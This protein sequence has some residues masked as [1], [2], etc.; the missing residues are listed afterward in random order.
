MIDSN[1]AL[2]GLIGYPLGH[3]LSPLM[4]NNAL[5]KMGLNCVYLP[6]QVEPHR[7]GAAL[8]GL[9]A[10]NFLGVNVTIPYKK[11]V[12]HLL[13][14]LSP[15]AKACGA[16]NLIKN[17]NGCLIGYN[18]DGKGFMAS[19]EEAGI[20]S[21]ATVLMI[22]A[23]GA[24]HSL[25]YE[26]TRA[27][28]AQLYV[29]DI[30]EEKAVALAESVNNWPGGRGTGMKMSTGNFDA[31]SRQADLIIN[32]T[33]V[34]MYPHVEKTVVDSFEGVPPNTVVYDLIYNPVVTRFISTAQASNLKTIN[35][36]SMLVHQGALTLEI[37]TGRRPALT[38][39]KE[40]IIDRVQ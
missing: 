23:G 20:E 4:H 40:V 29:L 38:S 16:V 17:D 31:L 30:I 12:V 26:L 6:L 11:E 21:H 35:G 7:L 19:L 27:G 13:D 33:P 14:K 39:M 10:L 5:D 25:A 3:S 28:T 22:G 37:L 18:T 32:C 1:T 36:M 24:A 8:E 34:G 15:E 9:K 2:M